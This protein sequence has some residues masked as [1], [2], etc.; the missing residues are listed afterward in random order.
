MYLLPSFIE[1]VHKLL[2]PT[3]GSGASRLP[4]GG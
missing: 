3:V 4:S 2:H 1:R